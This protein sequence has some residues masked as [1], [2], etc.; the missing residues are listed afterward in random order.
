MKPTRK[1]RR[2]ARRRRDAVK[3]RLGRARFDALARDLVALHRFAR[4]AGIIASLFGLEGPL[5]A[6]LRA[7]LCRQGWRWVDADF[8]ARTLLDEVYRRLKAE[9]PTWNEGQP[10]HVALPGLQIE[11]TRCVRCHKKLPE[12]HAKFCSRLCAVACHS[13]IRWRKERS[14]RQAVQAASNWT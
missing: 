13:S 1:D 4:E 10:E 3:G 6:A 5:R 7:D 2:L 9:R 11:R 12:G 8:T 14:E